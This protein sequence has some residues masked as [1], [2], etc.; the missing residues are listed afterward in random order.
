[1]AAGTRSAVLDLAVLSTGATGLPAWWGDALA[2]Y[3]AICLESQDHASGV[4]MN[5]AG[6]YPARCTISWATED[7]SASFFGND[8]ACTEHG[9]YGVAALLAY[10]LADLVVV[11]QAKIGG[12]FDFWLR[13][14]GDDVDEDDLF[15]NAIRFEVSGIREPG[16]SVGTRTRVKLKQTQQSDSMGVPAI[17]AVVE[18]GAPESRMVHR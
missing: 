2:K 8:K 4:A 5:V 15:Q 17:V 16:Q 10:E 12:G 7:L 13:P 18:F 11:Q 3:A 9:A 6:D 1:M 14:K